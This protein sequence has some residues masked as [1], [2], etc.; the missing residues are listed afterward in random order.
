MR[1]I[2]K[3]AF[4]LLGLLPGAAISGGCDK[5]SCT[6]PEK[7]WTCSVDLQPSAACSSTCGTT[8]G[9]DQTP[10]CATTDADAK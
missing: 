5:L 9:Y 4:L 1:S 6:P 2:L 3:L 7:A 10:L 8:P